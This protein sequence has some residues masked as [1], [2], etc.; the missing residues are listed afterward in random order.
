MGGVGVVLA[1]HHAPL[2]AAG[3]AVMDGRRGAE[4][5][6]E[7]RRPG[8]PLAQLNTQLM[9]GCLVLEPRW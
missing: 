7:G 8:G 3:G 6:D 1:L 4:E 5:R 9:D 2:V